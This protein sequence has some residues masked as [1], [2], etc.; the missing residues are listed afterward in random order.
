MEIKITALRGLPIRGKKILFRPDINS[1][2]DPQTGKIANDNRLQKNGATLQYMLENGAAVAIIAHQGDTQDYQNLGPLAEHAEKLTKLTGHR[3]SYI[4]D[5]CGPAAL[6]AVRT[7]PAGEAIILGNLRYL[8][9]E[10]STFSNFVRLS[11][12]QMKNVWHVRT[13]APLFDLYVNNAFSAA[14]RD[15]PS[16]VAFPALLPS[17]AGF[18]FFDEY[19]AL[20]GVLHGAEHPTLFVLGGAKV[21]DAF[22]MMESVLKNG[23]A[24][25][26]LTTGVTGIIMHLA[27]GV[28]FGE[29]QMQFLR[30]RD[31]LSF[32][33]PAQHYLERYPNRFEL[34]RDLAYAQNDK[35][36][37]CPVSD[38]MP[39]ELFGDIGAQT[40]ADYRALLAG[41]KTIFANGPAGRYE[42]PL[43]AHGTRGIWQAIADAPAYSV[44]GGGDTVTSATN[45]V[46]KEHFSYVCT[47]GGAMVR[48]LSGKK[49]PLIAAMEQAYQ[50]M[51]GEKRAD[52]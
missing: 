35:R 43:F 26:I 51:T 20:S 25:R 48:F 12:E 29:K 3:V 18:Q 31:M 8:G 50:R 32:I 37:E 6:Q 16:M 1:P 36:Q 10:L 7:L 40:I 2:L 42:H 45:Y 52:G 38:V 27:R 15:A 22:G 17:A 13:L 14:H 28:C 41:A 24:D 19:E 21:S 9:E 30:E 49:L 11:E 33:E 34:P 47:A 5:V 4:D 23:T 39:D 44:I 46:G